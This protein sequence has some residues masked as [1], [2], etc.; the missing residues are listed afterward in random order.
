MLK[1][2]AHYVS[3]NI[4]ERYSRQMRKFNVLFS[5]KTGIFIINNTYPKSQSL[6]SPFFVSRIFCGF[7]S[8]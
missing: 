3:G 6:T 4:I 7:I 5:V 1:K 8:R 2:L